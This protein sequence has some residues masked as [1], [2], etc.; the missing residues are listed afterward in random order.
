[1]GVLVFVYILIKPV[2]AV[3]A[4]HAPNT[5]WGKNS[6]C[7]IFLWRATPR[8]SNQPEDLLN[9]FSGFLISV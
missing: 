5:R 2:E 9:C 3:F 7:Q 8:D 4:N 1:M 6:L